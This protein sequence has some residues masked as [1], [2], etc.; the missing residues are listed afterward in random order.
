MSEKTL[1]EMKSEVTRDFDLTRPM[2]EQANED[3]RFCNVPGGMWE[4]FL[5]ETHGE[6]SGHARL[7]LDIVSDYVERFCGEWTMNRTNV[8]FTPSDDATSD[9]DADLLNSIYRADFKDNGGQN[10][11]DNA[12]REA[13]YTGYGAFLIRPQYADEENEDDENQDVGWRTIWNAYNQVVWDSNAKEADKSDAKHV[14][15]LWA[16][17]EDAFKREWPGK[18]PVSAYTPKSRGFLNQNWVSNKLIYVA[19][20]YEIERTRTRIHVFQNVST[21]AIQKVEEKDLADAREELAQLGF[22][23]TRSRRV[24]LKRVYRTVYNGEEILESR[25][26]VV[27]KWLP[28]IPVYGYRSYVDNAETARGLVRKLKDAQRLFNA[29]ISRIAETAAA[30]PDE[31]PIFTREQIQGLEDHWKNLTNK[32]YA[33]INSVVGEDGEVQLEGPVGYLKPPAVD[34]NTI[35]GTEL[36]TNFVE[37]QT[38]NMFQ[39]Q[40]DP[41]A[42]GKAI[43]TLLKRS[44][45]NTQT[46]SDNIKQSIKHS[47][48]VYQAQYAEVY[49]NQRTKRTLTASGD[50]STAQLF[51]MEMNPQTGLLEQRNV[52]TTGRFQV[53]VEV[54]PQ[55]ETQKEAT[56]ES[57]E[58]VMERLP[59]DSPYFMPLLSMWI[60]NIVGTGLDPL[61]DFNRREMLMMGLV[62]PRTDEEREMLQAQ[63]DQAQNDPNDEFIRAAAA[64]EM[65]QAEK[66]ASDTEKGYASADKLEAETAQI[67]DEI[68][69]NRIRELLSIAGQRSSDQQGAPSNVTLQ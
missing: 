7:E 49:S 11:Q 12:V 33:L 27:G 2:R 3:M 40:L 14:N 62:K 58:R 16:Y 34:P 32:A 22:K 10:A 68:G 21:G 23:F 44:N 38:G 52:P 55:Y 69:M 17:G 36:V 5:T 19:E 41:D 20:R 54:G 59:Q 61:K 39:D 30:A 4:D 1:D 51:K 25:R 24:T 65:A 29:N 56:L 57:I 37:R 64:K 31:R 28:V 43:T 26:R 9:D 13:A 46:V 8:T 47:G 15:L 42:S 6:G 45:L 60:E 66:L 63:A 35:A 18:T 53:D 50:S 67:I 48:R